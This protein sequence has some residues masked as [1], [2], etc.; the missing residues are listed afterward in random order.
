MSQKEFKVIEFTK[1]QELVEFVNANS[2]KIE[3][4]SISS[5]QESWNYK[6]FLW[7]YKL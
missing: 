3:I 5:S 7:F 2:E 6:H 1:K 4:V